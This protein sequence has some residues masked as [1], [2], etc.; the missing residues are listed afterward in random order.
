MIDKK[1]KGVYDGIALPTGVSATAAVGEARTAVEKKPPVVDISGYDNLSMSLDHWSG[2][3]DTITASLQQVSLREK[4][5]QNL[6]DFPEVP[7]H[8]KRA[9][10]AELLK[11]Q[12]SRTELERRLDIAGRQLRQI[13]A[14]LEPMLPEVARQKQ[15]RSLAAALR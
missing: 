8:E 1:L 5:A 2:V 9:A 15:I 13:K 12:E 3:S 11:C 10:E 7:S 14:S 6:L 4:A